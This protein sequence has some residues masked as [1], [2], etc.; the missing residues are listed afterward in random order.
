[1]HFKGY[2]PSQIYASEKKMT[3]GG[4]S[5]GELG[6]V[7]FYLDSSFEGKI[8]IDVLPQDFVSQ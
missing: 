8:D 1:M 5:D 3:E 6:D 7:F 4:C 2:A